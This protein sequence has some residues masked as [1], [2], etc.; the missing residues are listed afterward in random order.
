M[1]A[2]IEMQV[3]LLQNPLSPF[4]VSLSA[5]PYSLPQVLHSSLS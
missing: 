4:L 3:L 5:Y 2:G 1:K